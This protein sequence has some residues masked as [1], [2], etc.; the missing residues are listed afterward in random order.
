MA[1]K[2]A[3]NLVSKQKRRFTQ[4]G[5]DLDLSYITECIIAMGIPSQGTVSSPETFLSL[6]T[7][8]GG[9]ER[10]N[11]VSVTVVAAC[12]VQEGLFRNNMDDVIKFFEH[13][14]PSQAKIFNLCIEDDRQYEVENFSGQVA[15]FPFY[16]HNCPPLKIIPK[17]CADATEWL[18]RHESNVV[19][20]HC[21]AGK[22]RTGLMVVCLL[23]HMRGPSAL[24]AAPREAVS[25]HLLPACARRPRRTTWAT[26]RSCGR[27]RRAIDLFGGGA[28][29]PHSGDEGVALPGGGR[30]P[31][32]RGGLQCKL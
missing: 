6:Y 12:R 22:S 14:H 7:P 13:Y 19:A 31:V 27:S 5:F 9:W 21:K 10:P 15:S 23:M 30:L 25:P 32:C 3:R 4:D 18:G 28:A 24:P 8:L 11:W 26:T 16:D 2:L 1:T 29:R 17:F 20:V